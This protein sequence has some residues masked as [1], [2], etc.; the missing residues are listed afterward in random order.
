MT[1]KTAKGSGNAGSRIMSK[2]RTY[3]TLKSLPT[4]KS[5]QSPSLLSQGK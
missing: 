5:L 4:F 1:L 3:L 2:I